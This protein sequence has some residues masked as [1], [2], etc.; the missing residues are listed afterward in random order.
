MRGYRKCIL[1]LIHLSNEWADFSKIKVFFHDCRCTSSMLYG[2]TNYAEGVTLKS[3]FTGT[4]SITLPPN[5]EPYLGFETNHQSPS[6]IFRPQGDF[7]TNQQPISTVLSHVAQQQESVNSPFLKRPVHQQL[8]N[9]YGRR[10]GLIRLSP[11]KYRMNEPS[12]LS[13]AWPSPPFRL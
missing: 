10:E 3:P 11:T 2:Q 9:Y 13:L 12:P 4:L 5:S 1:H 6:T 7:P 8:N